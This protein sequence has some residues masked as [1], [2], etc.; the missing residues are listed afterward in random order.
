MKP[1]GKPFSK[2]NKGKP[3]GAT[4]ITTKKAKELVVE[5]VEKGLPKAFEKLEEI[6]NPKDYLDTLSKFIAYVIPKQ[7]EVEVNDKRI[8]VKVPGEQQDEE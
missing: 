6:K 2:G 1:R 4:N 8:K 3:K 5:L 7:T